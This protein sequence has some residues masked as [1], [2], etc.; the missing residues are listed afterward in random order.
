MFPMYRQFTRR[1]PRDRT[2]QESRGYEEIAIFSY[3]LDWS[4][5]R[6]SEHECPLPCQFRLPITDIPSRE[7][8]FD[9]RLWTVPDKFAHGIAV[10]RA[11][12]PREPFIE[13]HRV[14]YSHGGHILY[15]LISADL[16]FKFGSNLPI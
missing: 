14:G 16:W 12:S 5:K 7:Q 6:K 9:C 3:L 11:G 1:R 8:I 15:A 10:A 2:A 4:F 13:E